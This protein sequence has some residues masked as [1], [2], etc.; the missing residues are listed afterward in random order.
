MTSSPVPTQGTSPSSAGRPA[1]ASVILDVDSTLSNLEGID[2]LAGLR[3]PVMA[4]WVR[5]LTDQAMAGRIRVEEVFGQR[6]DKVAPT[7][8]ELDQLGARYIALAAPEARETVRAFQDAGIQVALVSGGLLPSIAHLAKW[9]GVPASHTHAVNVTFGP[10]GA[11]V[12]FD[13]TSP[14][15]TQIGKPLL[16]RELGL[17]RPLLA[18]GDGITDLAIRTAGAADAFA[19][20]TA[21]AHRDAVVAGADHVLTSF[22]ALR[23]LVLDHPA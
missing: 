13:T 11:Y 5:Q 21:F 2:W 14:M 8:H 19:A 9:L 17:P 7:Q 16:V 23:S 18:V 20:F 1:F 12:G 6:L 15:T 10:D 3:G 22:A 4:E